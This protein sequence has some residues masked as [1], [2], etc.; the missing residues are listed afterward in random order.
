MIKLKN[1]G[2][3]IYAAFLSCEEES[4]KQESTRIW[5]SSQTRIVDLCDEH[6]K[7]AREGIDYGLE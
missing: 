1:P 6:Y 5:A 3:S 7:I 4:C 2:A